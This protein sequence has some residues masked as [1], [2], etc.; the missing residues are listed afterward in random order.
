[1]NMSRDTDDSVASIA[2]ALGY[3]SR[4]GFA[5]AFRK[6]TNESSSVGG[7]AD[8]SCLHSTAIMQSRKSLDQVGFRADGQKTWSDSRRRRDGV[9]NLA[10]SFFIRSSRGRYE[11]T[12]CVSPRPRPAHD[13]APQH[14]SCREAQGP[15]GLP[16]AAFVRD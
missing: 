2:A 14:R 15:R 4:T 3:S 10:G 5:A 11:P 7:G 8:V 9:S 16:Y 1:M 13:V 6:S 12:S